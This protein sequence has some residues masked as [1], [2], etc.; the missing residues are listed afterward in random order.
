MRAFLG[1]G[2]NLGDRF[3]F[4]RR[5]VQA[6]PDLVA[7]SPVY[8]SEPVGGPDQGAYLN[9]VVELDTTLTPR[10]LLRVCRELERQARRVRRVRW[11]PRTLDVD[12]LWVE[13]VA[14]EEDDLTVPHARMHER[15]FVMRPL[16]DLAPDLDVPG[17]DP[18][19]AVGDVEALG[20]LFELE[21][22]PRAD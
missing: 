16:L 21:L 17:W 5:A 10:R 2:S 15:N 4:L 19:T 11:G 6:V 9:I 12:V 18:E 7:V 13:G 3:E 1:L 8:E 22:S 20:D 14:V